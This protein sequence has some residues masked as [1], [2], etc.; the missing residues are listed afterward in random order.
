M[1]GYP[2]VGA[3]ATTK[4]IA[5][6][7]EPRRAVRYTIPATYK[8]SMTMKTS[9]EM[10][11]LPM[12]MPPIGMVMGV[13]VAVTSIAA[14]GDISTSMTFTKASVDAS[15]D[16]TI[17]G[18][19]QAGLGGIVGLKGTAVMTNRGVTK[20][21]KLDLDSIKDPAM[22]QALSQMSQSLENMLAPF[23]EEPIGVGARWE[24]RN[25]L[26][27]NGMA[28]FQRSEYEVTAM[29]ASAITVRVK[30][31]QTAPQQAIS[32][33]AMPAEVQMSLERMTGTG[34]ATGTIPTNALVPTMNMDM[35][36]LMSMIVN[37][38]GQSLPIS[39]EMKMKTSMA[40]GGGK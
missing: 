2:A 13:D 29:T 37:A 30:I 25:A 14:N 6:G 17:A 5:P 23:P 38:A 22:G 9:I 3:P 31:E 36:M 32:N 16:P 7:A 20:S 19:M 40:P 10:A 15:V 21:V 34:T 18:A 24:S 28:M 26:D 4:L 39:M 35:S 27:A 12:A 1:P 33:P 11:G 8:G